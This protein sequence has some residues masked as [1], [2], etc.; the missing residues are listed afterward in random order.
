MLRRIFRKKIRSDRG[1][2]ALISFIMLTPLFLGLVITAFDTSFYFSNRGQVDAIAKDAART[3]A[4]FGGNGNA[5]RATTIEKSYGSDKSTACSQSRAATNNVPLP[6]LWTSVNKGDYTPIEC[7]ALFA[8]VS[9]GG[10]VSV[11]MDKGGEGVECG[12]ERAENVGSRTFC[13]ITY[14]YDGMP[15]APLSF[16]QMRQDD[17]T[18]GGLLSKNVVTKSSES[19]VKMSAPLVNR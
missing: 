13:T 14:T 17:G 10:L 1:G 2:S 16:V 9:N 12:P 19:E 18:S 4:I 3:I 8:L 7:N 11:S 15:G 6:D 5:T